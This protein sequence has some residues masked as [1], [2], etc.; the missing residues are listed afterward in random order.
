[1]NKEYYFYKIISKLYSFWSLRQAEAKRLLW[2]KA[3][4]KEDLNAANKRRV[5]KNFS[6]HI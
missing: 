4:L 1:M 5:L 3:H 2:Y 6:F